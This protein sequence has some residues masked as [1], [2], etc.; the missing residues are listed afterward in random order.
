[1]P[2]ST[3]E[4]YQ[5]ERLIAPPTGRYGYRPEDVRRLRL[6]R[7]LVEVGG[8]NPGQVRELLEAMGAEGR[9]PHETFGLVLRALEHPPTGRDPGVEPVDDEACFLARRIA[10]RHGWT[11]DP[12]SASWNTLLKLLRTLHWLDEADTEIVVE[13]YAAAAERLTRAEISVLGMYADQ[14]A[15][16][17]RLVL[18]TVFGDPLLASLRRIARQDRSRRVF[19]REPLPDEPGSAL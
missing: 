8:L 13:A 7:V 12:E 14:D 4:Y 16:V 17:E 19:D 15:L 5:R 18:W 6:V 2:V 9:T 11:V 1:M 3:V 10:R